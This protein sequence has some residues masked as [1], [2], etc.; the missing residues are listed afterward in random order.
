M[1]ALTLSF[2]FAGAAGM[3]Q[4]LL[5]IRLLGLQWGQTAQ[6][7]S[8]VVAVYLLGQAAGNLLAEIFLSRSAS[9]GNSL[10]II[11]YYF[12]LQFGIALACW[13]SPTVTS[14]SA[15]GCLALILFASL[16]SGASFPLLMRLGKNL[17]PALWSARLF[18]FNILGSIGGIGLASFFTPPLLGISKS[19]WLASL[20][21]LTAGA[22]PSLFRS[23]G[24]P[25]AL[26]P[27]APQNPSASKFWIFA[28]FISSLASLIYE[29]AWIR[30]LTMAIGSTNFAFA[31]IL[32]AYFPGLAL[33]NGIFAIANRRWGS[34]SNGLG[35]LILVWAAS[36]LGGFSL[37]ER[38]PYWHY[39]F[40]KAIQPSFWL[41]QAWQIIL[42]LLIML[43]PTTL[44]GISLPWFL[45]L[46]GPNQP[47]RLYAANLA[48]A[49]AGSLL[50]G[51][52]AIPSWGA[53]NALKLGIF[54][55][56]I[57]CTIVFLFN[58]RRMLTLATGLM[59]VIT[60]LWPS[61]N[62]KI[63]SSGVF[64]HLESAT[65]APLWE[66]FRSEL[67]LG[68][69]LFHKDGAQA[70][71]TVWQGEESEKLLIING[72]TDAS[73]RPDDM[74][75]QLVLGY[76]P[77]LWHPQPQK[78]LVIGLGSGVTAGAVS[79][80]ASIQRID[81]IEI[82]PAVAQ[83]ARYFE[84][85][86]KMI[87]QDRRLNLIYADARSQLRRMQQKYDLIISEPSNLWV[88]GS[89]ALL[90]REA[91]EAARNH[92]ENGGILCQWLHG[93]RLQSQDFRSAVATFLSVFPRAVLLAS[94]NA[95]DYLL[96]S[97]PDFGY[98]DLEH[99]RRAAGGAIANDLA[100]FNWNDPATLVAGSVLL[101]PSELAA[102]AQGG[103]LNT[104][105]RPTLEFNAPVGLYQ[106]QSKKIEQ[107]LL[108]FKTEAFP[109][110]LNLLPPPDF[111]FYTHLGSWQLRRNLWE[112]AL[113]TFQQA[114]TLRSADAIAWLGLARSQDG[115]G[116]RKEAERSYLKAISLNSNHGPTY[117]FYGYLLLRQERFAESAA[118]F[119]QFARL[120][121]K[122]PDALINAGIAFLKAGQKQKAQAYFKKAL[123]LP[124]I[125]DSQRRFLLQVAENL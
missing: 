32:L 113:L 60:G 112:P 50:A 73:S 105:E 24:P 102:Y 64:V 90:T 43:I 121:L 16:A 18:T 22:L 116:R 109:K 28:C 65:A 61:W 94:P 40:L 17:E 88:S 39:S 93:Y 115:L 76:F 15:W 10:R 31:I 72:K 63:L 74:A 3:M 36:V 6:T 92:L 59:A 107:E 62:E 86:N 44:A 123:A 53:Q 37:L 19:L 78:A 89:A 49:A 45:R 41:G 58:S 67:E 120:D 8:C 79:Q 56:L 75:T 33:G 95:G 2:G 91:L 118:Q 25:T 55:H 103:F 23:A 29:I 80:I 68:T 99:L 48:G 21:N 124:S 71:V 26:R 38:L 98:L 87:L 119:A 46:S 66:T 114:I 82:E 13:A 5:W 122:N 104:D 101:G 111:S 34:F 7:V 83:A 12:S 110:E 117:S 108:S 14:Q 20:F 96:M 54:I 97:L 125:N 4:E 84:P 51:L 77:S 70:T 100:Q 106:D 1:W 81:A 27:E 30:P 69:I 11:K 57:L 9:A 42:G 85:Q 47:G 52:V 35:V